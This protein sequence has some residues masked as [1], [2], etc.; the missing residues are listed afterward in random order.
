MVCMIPLSY[1]NVR[2]SKKC[3]K[4]LSMKLSLKHYQ[5]QTNFMCIRDHYTHCGVHELPENPQTIA[6]K[7]MKKH[8][9]SKIITFGKILP[10]RLLLFQLNL[11][12]NLKHRY[13]IKAERKAMP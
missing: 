1:G 12:P 6:I 10:I 7:G 9:P 11:Y 2:Y 13:C 5:Q 3:A 8:A 4:L